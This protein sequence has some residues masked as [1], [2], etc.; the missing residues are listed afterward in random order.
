MARKPKNPTVIDA[1]EYIK[2]ATKVIRQYSAEFIERSGSGRKPKSEGGTPNRLPFAYRQTMREFSP[3]A[4]DILK[5]IILDDAVN[6]MVRVMAIKEVNDRAWGRVASAR[7]DDGDV[8]RSKK[9][10]VTF[11]GDTSDDNKPSQIIQQSVESIEYNRKDD[12]DDE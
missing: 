9:I 10:Q 2:P 8:I 7:D 4:N 5:K 3:E 6:P 12:I 1:D 11:V